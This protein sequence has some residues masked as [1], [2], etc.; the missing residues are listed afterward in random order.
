MYIECSIMKVRKQFYNETKFCAEKIDNR[1]LSLRLSFYLK[2]ENLQTLN[3][4][5]HLHH[6]SRNVHS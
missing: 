4:L 5:H 1:E 2:T 6:Q 3:R